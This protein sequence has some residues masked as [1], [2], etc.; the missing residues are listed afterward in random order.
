MSQVRRCRILLVEDEA[1][2]RGALARALQRAGYDVI[3]AGDVTTALANVGGE[4]DLAHAP[5]PW[6]VR[7]LHAH[8]RRRARRAANRIGTRILR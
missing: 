5:E 2:A 1:E 4:I 6:L 7:L 8:R 3:E